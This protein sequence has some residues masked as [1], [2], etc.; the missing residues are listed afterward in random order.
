MKSWIRL[1][2]FHF[3]SVVREVEWVA[4][5]SQTLWGHSKTLSDCPQKWVT[6]IANWW[7]ASLWWVPGSDLPASGMEGDGGRDMVM[8]MMNR[9]FGGGTNVMYVSL[10]CFPLVLSSVQFNRSVVSNSVT[11][12][13]AACQA[14]LSIAD[15][16]TWTCSNSCPLNQWCHSTIS[17]SVVPFSSCLQS[18]PASRSFPMSLFFISGGQS[19]GISASAS[20]LPMKTQDW[21]PLGWTGWISLQSKGLSRV[22]SNTTVQKSQFFGN[23]ISL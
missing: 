15:S 19:I 6:Y 16:Q 2:H 23:Q 13:T 18:F 22:L 8:V 7:R 12:W 3:L 20:I 5:E 4:S 9:D 14:S 21:S 17:Y 1:S 10:D 11:P